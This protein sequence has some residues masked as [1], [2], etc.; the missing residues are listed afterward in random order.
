MLYKEKMR[1]IMNYN[2]NEEPAIDIILL[3]DESDFQQNEYV[4]NIQKT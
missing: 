2:I 1:N 3:L 4:I